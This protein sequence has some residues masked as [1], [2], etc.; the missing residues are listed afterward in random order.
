MDLFTIVVVTAA[1]LGVLLLVLAVI[2]IV[3]LLPPVRRAMRERAQSS[4]A[5][6]EGAGSDPETSSSDGAEPEQR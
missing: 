1:V 5:D 3:V 4:E 2:A 6:V